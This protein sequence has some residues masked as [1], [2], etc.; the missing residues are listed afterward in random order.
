MSLWSWGREKQ[1][2]TYIH[3]PQTQGTHL[4]EVVAEEEPAHGVLHALGHLH[5][6]LQNVARGRL[7]RL[8]VHAGHGHEEV[9]AGE[10]VPAALH[11]LVELHLVGGFVLGFGG[12]GWSV[13]WL[14]EWL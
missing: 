5:Q 14:D 8:D 4:R 13:G 1:T 9:E 3:T 2:H 7:E 11:L 10:D 12:I 6:V